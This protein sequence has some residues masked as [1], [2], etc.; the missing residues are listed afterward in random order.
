MKKLCLFL[1]LTSFS[2]FAMTQELHEKIMVY[3]LR[4]DTSLKPDYYSVNISVSEYYHSQKISKKKYQVNLVSLDTL[5][6][7][8][9]EHL[10]GL[11]FHQNISKSSV[12]EVDDPGDYYIRRSDKKLFKVTYSY[13]IYNKDSVDHLFSNIDRTIVS[14]M[15]IR[16]EVYDATVENAK[17]LLIPKGMKAADDYVNGIAQKMNQKVIKSKYNV[18]F[19]DGGVNSNHIEF[20][21]KFVIDYTDIKYNLSVS[22][23]YTL[24]EK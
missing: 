19:Y 5:T 4:L 12:T 10:S 15:I 6:K 21:K 13:R 9:M 7:K 1:L 18:V 24:A 8:L 16:P 11:G 20:G 23:T 22:Y 3:N 14:G 2:F 17:Q